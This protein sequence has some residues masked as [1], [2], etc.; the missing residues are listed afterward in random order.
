MRPP[1]VQMQTDRGARLGHAGVGAQI[2][3]LVC[4]GFPDA[5]DD[6][7]GR[8]SEYPSGASRDAPFRRA[9][10]TP[11]APHATLLRTTGDFGLFK[12]VISF[13]INDL[14]TYMVR[15][16]GSNRPSI[17]SSFISPA[18]MA[19]LTRRV[20]DRGSVKFEQDPG[21]RPSIPIEPF[22]DGD[23][24]DQTICQSVDRRAFLQDTSH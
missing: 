10:S 8:V 17:G 24:K 23:S 16:T 20:G 22:R 12:L 19:A 15:Q 1:F 21:N 13:I 5:L 18:D 11:S 14:H 3:L 9:K 6:P 4:D 2:D 7:K